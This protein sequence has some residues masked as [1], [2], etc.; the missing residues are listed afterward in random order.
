MHS[1]CEESG[2]LNTVPLEQRRSL[3]GGRPDYLESR[4]TEP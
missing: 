3:L 4:H 2:L 1:W